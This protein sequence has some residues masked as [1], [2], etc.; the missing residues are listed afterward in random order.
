MNMHEPSVSCHLGY[1]HTISVSI[2]TSTKKTIPNDGASHNLRTMISAGFLQRS[3]HI[4][5]EPVFLSARKLP[6][7]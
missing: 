1:V 6:A 5:P 7:I 4:I 2:C 3:G